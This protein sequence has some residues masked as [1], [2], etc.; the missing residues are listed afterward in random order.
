MLVLSLEFFGAEDVVV[1]NTKITNLI[2][3]TTLTSQL[4]SDMAALLTLY[5]F[6]LHLEWLIQH[7]STLEVLF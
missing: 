4:K 1:A 3:T 5:L 2:L 7:Y 6:A